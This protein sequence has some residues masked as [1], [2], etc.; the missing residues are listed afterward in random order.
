MTMHQPHEHGFSAG[1]PH[2]PRQAP[3]APS[4]ESSAPAEGSG[5]GF[6]ADEPALV[7]QSMI[8]LGQACG[9]WVML[10]ADGQL[11]CEVTW[12]AGPPLALKICNDAHAWLAVPRQPQFSGDVVEMP[13]KAGWYFV[14][15]SDE[16]RSE[17][18]RFSLRV[19]PQAAS[20]AA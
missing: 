11:S 18:R 8:P 14:T 17:G 19:W 15:V 6:P 3:P 5:V 7:L 9:E 13:M 16:S 10:P 4:S 12:S 1:H 2:D 20:R